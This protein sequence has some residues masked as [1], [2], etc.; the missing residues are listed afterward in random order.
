MWIYYFPN[1]L[2]A[3]TRSSELTT[4]QTIVRGCTSRKY[5]ESF[6]NLKS[7]THEAAREMLDGTYGDICE[8]IPHA[9][10][11]I[12]FSDVSPLTNCKAGK[13]F[14]IQISLHLFCDGS[15]HAK[16]LY[17]FIFWFVVREGLIPKQHVNLVRGKSPHKIP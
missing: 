3:C 1:I 14:K 12:I 2:Q 7:L 15:P 16:F 4:Q 10:A 13:I 9:I 5:K 11:M 17:N 8:G 6:A